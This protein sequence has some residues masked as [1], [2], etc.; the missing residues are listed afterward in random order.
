MEK[1][2]YPRAARLY[3]LA[4]L[5]GRVD[6]LRVSDESAHQ[7]VTV[8]RLNNLASFPQDE[9][10]AMLSSIMSIAN[11]ADALKA[12]CGE[13]RSIGPPAYYPAYMTQ[14]GMRAVL[15]GSSTPIRPNFDMN[16]AW[17]RSLNDFL[18]C[19]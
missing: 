2:D 14:H 15:G 16:E 1:K 11:N 17:S 8:V 10:D 5:Y 4:S 3:A 13:I 18:H 19:P 12:M 9:M 6:Q 7:A